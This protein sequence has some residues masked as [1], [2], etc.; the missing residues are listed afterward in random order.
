MIELSKE[1]MDQILHEETTKKEESDTILRGIYTRYMR[2][3]EKYFSD[4][5]A[6]DD[7][8]IAEMKKYHEETISLVKYYYMDIPQDVCD[9][10]REFEK[11]YNV[12]LL[13]PEWRK[14][15][16]DGYKEFKAGSESRNKSEEFYKAEFRKKILE[17]FYDA[18]D[19]VEQSRKVR[20]IPGPDR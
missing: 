15:L 5:D 7:D 16:S 20:L 11:K 9:G 3:Y 1:R 12:N 2:L 17:S 4:L 13:G 18:M 19:Y 6:L 14:Y 8:K 10:I